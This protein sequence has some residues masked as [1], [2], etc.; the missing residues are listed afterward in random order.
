MFDLQPKREEKKIW[1][2]V[3]LAWQIK[4]IRSVKADYK[5]C[6]LLSASINSF[7]SS[8]SSSDFI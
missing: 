4:L 8:I 5:L 2:E 3:E 7:D 6:F 1:K